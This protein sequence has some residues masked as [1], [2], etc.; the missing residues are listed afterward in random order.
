MNETENDKRFVRKAKSLFDD[1]VEHLDAATLSR[2]TRSRHRALEELERA[3]H[4]WPRAFWIPAT[5]IAA[6]M[7]VALLVLRVPLDT[8]PPIDQPLARDFDMLLEEDSLEMFEELEFYSW[9]EL[10]DA[11]PDD[12]VG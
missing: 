6:A 10:A 3:G 11:Q 1:S 9:L 2:L 5:G 4:R 8:S 12:H 7:L